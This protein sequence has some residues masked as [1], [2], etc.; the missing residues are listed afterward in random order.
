MVCITSIKAGNSGQQIK[1]DEARSTVKLLDLGTNNPEGIGIE[2]Q[3]QQ[4]DM[5]EDR[6][7][8]PP[9]LS[10]EDFRVGLHTECHQCGL[11]AAAAG[12]SHQEENEDIQ[13]EKQIS[14]GRPAS[15]NRMKEIEVVFRN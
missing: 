14:K 4:A 8:K 6:R 7:H 9:P 5:D 1:N 11:I 10:L 15:P 13:T 2:K 3:M 12:K